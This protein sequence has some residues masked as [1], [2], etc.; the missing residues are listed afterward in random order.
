MPMGHPSWVSFPEIPPFS[1]PSGLDPHIKS[2]RP[3]TRQSDPVASVMTEG[4]HRTGTPMPRAL[5]P[6]ENTAS[7]GTELA[8][9]VTPISPRAN[10]DSL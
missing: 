10:T 6:T 1:P 7:T 5:T 9:N 2:Y 8:R 4:G 3:H